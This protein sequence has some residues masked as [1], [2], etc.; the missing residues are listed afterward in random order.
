MVDRLSSQ[1][2]TVFVLKTR[3]DVSIQS[4][5]NGQKNW[6]CSWFKFVVPFQKKVGMKPDWNIFWTWYRLVSCKLHSP[7]MRNIQF[8]RKWTDIIGFAV[9]FFNT[10]C[11][12]S[13]VLCGA[14][15][16]KLN[17]SQRVIDLQIGKWQLF[18]LFVACWMSYSVRFWHWWICKRAL[19]HKGGKMCV[20][21]VV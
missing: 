5:D 20:L 1:S 13:L 15:N 10:L 7:L 2:Q 8:S 16:K 11:Y 12:S 3:L 18:G 4:T 9:F 14:W 6:Q 19:K 21:Y 17:P